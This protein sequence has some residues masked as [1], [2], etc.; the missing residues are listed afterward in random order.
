M[1]TKLASVVQRVLQWVQLYWLAKGPGLSRFELFGNP[2]WEG[3]QNPL[4]QHGT[5]SS[6]RP[7]PAARQHQAFT[8]LSPLCITSAQ[9][10]RHGAAAAV[11]C[12]C[13]QVWGMLEYMDDVLGRLFDF[14]ERSK[15]RENTYVLV[16]SDNGAELYPE[17]RKGMH[18]Q[19]RREQGHYPLGLVVGHIQVLHSW[20]MPSKVRLPVVC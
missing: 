13:F 3:W 4:T 8:L 19:V 5:S 9:N 12:G 2:P 16:M 14:M 17:E 18:R 1:T 7:H 11:G 20:G 6:L 15:L 10:D